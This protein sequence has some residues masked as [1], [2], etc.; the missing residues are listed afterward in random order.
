MR[1]DKSK[2][3]SGLLFWGASQRDPDRSRSGNR[4]RG[5]Q[6]LEKLTWLVRCSQIQFDW[7]SWTL[8]Q[9][10][11][12][13]RELLISIF[14]R[15]VSPPRNEW[16]ANLKCS[17]LSSA[18][19]AKVS[20]KFCRLQKRAKSQFQFKSQ[21]TGIVLLTDQANYCFTSTNSKSN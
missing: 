13:I 8:R 15:F 4:W 18:F 1:S 17:L 19:A 16:G 5:S 9:R 11:H 6:G 3:A 7:S 14:I 21:Q 12:E 2:W 20:V 10:Y